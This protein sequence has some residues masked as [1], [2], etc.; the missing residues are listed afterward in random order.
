MNTEMVD[1]NLALH[2]AGSR[3]KIFGQPEGASNDM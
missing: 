1:S 3:Y 2:N